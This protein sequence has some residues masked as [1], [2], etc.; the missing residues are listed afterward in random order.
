MA[1]TKYTFSVSQD[2]PNQK[3]NNDTLTYEIEQSDIT[4]A[5]SYIT[6]AGDVC[7]IVFKNA[8]TLVDSTATLPLVVSEHEGNRLPDA[9]PPT[10]EDGRPIVRADTRPLDYETFFTMAGDSTGIGTGQLIKWDF[11]NDDDEYTGDDVP[12]GFKAKRFE[13]TF[14]CPIHLKDGTIYFYN[15]P[16]NCYIDLDIY[17]PAGGYYPNDGGSIPAAALGL[18]GTQMYSYAATDTLYQRYVNRHHMYG[19][20]PMGD[21]LNAEGAAVNALP[22]GW[23]LVG[24]VYTPTSDTTSKGFG[25]LEMYRCHTVLKEGQTPD[26]IH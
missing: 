24:T 4:T 26:T 8:L 25:S 22:I 11:S 7:D 15:A 3:V 16:W 23:K 6:V 5:L 12:A 9:S 20:C 1:E 19:D 17:V 2:F 21:E 10:M 14:M 18:S 13:L